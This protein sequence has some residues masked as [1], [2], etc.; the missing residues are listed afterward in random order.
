MKIGRFALQNATLFPVCAN[1]IH[2]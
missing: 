1:Q 2:K